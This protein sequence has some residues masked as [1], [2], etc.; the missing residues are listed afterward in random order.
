MVFKPFNGFADGIPVEDS[1]VHM[2]D[3]PG[4]GFEAKNELYAVMKRML[5]GCCCAS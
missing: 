5:E 4:I 1:F 3:I 2:P